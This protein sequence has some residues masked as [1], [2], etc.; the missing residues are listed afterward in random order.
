MSTPE[1][2]VVATQPAP[3]PSEVLLHVT[4]AVYVLQAVGLF[5]PPVLVVGVILNY[6]K[7]ED[8]RGTF[9]ESH[10]RWQIRTFW[11]VLTWTIVGFLTWIILI[12]FVVLGVI[13]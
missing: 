9:L 5:I 3:T 7:R 11:F 4:T 1:E 13:W 6:V 10:F 8:V 2:R 12:G